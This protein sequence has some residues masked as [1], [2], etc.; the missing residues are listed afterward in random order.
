MTDLQKLTRDQLRN[1]IQPLVP[2]GVDA[3]EVIEGFL[4]SQTPPSER[5]L[6]IIRN[7]FGQKS[8]Y[9]WSSDDASVLKL[10]ME[11][12]ARLSEGLVEGH[13]IWLTLGI[14][15][16]EI[17]CF[18]I[19]LRRHGVSV[20]NPLH[21]K[22]LL[23]LHDAKTGLT[24][25]QLRDRL[26]SAGAPTT[27]QIVDALRALERADAKSGPKPLVHADLMTWKSLV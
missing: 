24:V 6:P 1:E 20:T 21:I 18:L 27:A 17:V 13:P 25:Q 16:K 11:V 22:V 12:F 23:A 3:E 26:V 5:T 9:A 7:P 8:L 15:L 2:K 14:G 19:D 4:L 10:A